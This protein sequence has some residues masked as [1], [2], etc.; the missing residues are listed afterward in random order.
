[1]CFNI[2]YDNSLIFSAVT[3]R[4]ETTPLRVDEGDTGMICVI[5]EGDIVGVATVTLATSD[6]E[7][8]GNLREKTAMMKYFM[9]D[10]RL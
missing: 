2:K 1:M 3:V 8:I 7:A 6:D 4:F 5:L 10:N 9:C